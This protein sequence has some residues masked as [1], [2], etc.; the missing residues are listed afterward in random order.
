MTTFLITLQKPC[1]PRA[2]PHN[3]TRLVVV[4][5]EAEDVAILC[6]RKDF[7]FEPAIHV[8]TIPPGKT[9]VVRG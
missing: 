2:N 7:P 9:F 5:A 3:H 6:A 1:G 8:T 4:V